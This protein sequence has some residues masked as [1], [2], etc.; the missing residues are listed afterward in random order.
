MRKIIQLFFTFSTLT[1]L[2]SA[3]SAISH[4]INS[5]Y[6]LNNIRSHSGHILTDITSQGDL[7]Q[8]EDGSYWNIPRSDFSTIYNWRAGD[9]LHIT[10][11]PFFFSY[12]TYAI[13]NISTGT[14]VLANLSIGPIANGIYTHWIT[15]LN[16]S[17]GQ[18]VLENGTLWK[19]YGSQ[20]DMNQFVKWAIG[21]T[22]IIGSNDRDYYSHESILINV[23]LNHYVRARIY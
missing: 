2:F 23:N 19:I 4:T 1:L 16:P 20:W 8:I 18:V 13:Q 6:S 11:N 3:Q 15:G 21:D 12:Y 22:L 17:S 9:H 5:Y 7:L 14:F 10:P